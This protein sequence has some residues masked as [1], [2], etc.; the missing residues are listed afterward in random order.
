MLGNFMK[1]DNFA[2]FYGV[3]KHKQ[4]EKNIGDLVGTFYSFT[5][6]KKEILFEKKHKLIPYCIFRKNI[7]HS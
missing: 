2:L 4:L 6:R 7:R 1:T 3:T 5:T